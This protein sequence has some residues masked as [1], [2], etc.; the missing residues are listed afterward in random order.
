MLFVPSRYDFPFPRYRPL[1][2]NVIFAVS[3]SLSSSRDSPLS[4][5]PEHWPISRLALVRWSVTDAESAVFFYYPILLLL[6]RVRMPWG[7]NGSRYFREFRLPFTPS[8]AFR[9]AR[10]QRLYLRNA[11]WYR[12]ETKCVL[13]S[14]ISSI[15]WG[16]F[17][18]L[19]IFWTCFEG[20]KIRIE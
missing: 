2:P 5:I 10:F 15:H 20:V 14:I 8:R 19:E 3:L 9:T 11:S 16:V 4:L 1:N 18:Y 6:R 12:D 13:K 17:V 7:K